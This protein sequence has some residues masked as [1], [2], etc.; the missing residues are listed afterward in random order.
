MS[1]QARVIYV[2]RIP[3]R[4][5]LGQL[6]AQIVMSF[7]RFLGAR[8]VQNETFNRFFVVFVCLGDELFSCFFFICKCCVQVEKG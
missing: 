2:Y 8:L 5:S 6:Q 7:R 3:V 4:P 1:Q